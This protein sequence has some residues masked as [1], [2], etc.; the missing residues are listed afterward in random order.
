VALAVERAGAGADDTVRSRRGSAPRASQTVFAQD[1]QST[2]TREVPV[3]AACDAGGCAS[4]RWGGS[5]CDAVAPP[6]I[7]YFFV[8]NS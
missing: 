6:F 8:G 5:M 1:R 2:I 7:D 3:R 4:K